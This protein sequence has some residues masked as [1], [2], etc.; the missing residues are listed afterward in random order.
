MPLAGLDYATR[1]RPDKT[2]PYKD[3]MRAIELIAKTESKWSRADIERWKKQ[4]ALLPDRSTKIPDGSW[5]HSQVGVNP[6]AQ[7]NEREHTGRVRELWNKAVYEREALH[8]KPVND[9]QARNY[10]MVDAWH[11]SD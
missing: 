2:N 3:T 4:A 8:Q 11:K 10:A 5:D 9:I 1:G 7:A 6:Q